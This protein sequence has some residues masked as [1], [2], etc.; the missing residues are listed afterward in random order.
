MDLGL[1]NHVALVAASSRGLGKAVAWGLAKEGTKL[2]ICSRNKEVLEK[3]ADE[4]LLET[5][6]TVFPLAMDLTNHEQIDWLIE[7]TMDLFG[8][9]DILV[10]NAGGPPPGDFNDVLE[11]D[12]KDSFHLNLMSAVRLT[13]AVIP[14][15]QKQK[16][17]RIIY[18]TSVTVKQYMPGMV[19]S[20]VIRPSILALMKNMSQELAKDNILVNSICPGYFITDRVKQLIEEKAKKEKKQASKIREEFITDIP[21]A[22]MGNPEEFANLI[23]FLASEKSSYITGSAISIDGGL[24]RGLL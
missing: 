19:L 21:L 4:I 23:V 18:M 5:G 14:G 2:V 1:K 11:I 7:E 6:V 12:W 15:M 3:T 8:R 17:G 22:R 13:K 20:N 24:V 16:W 9:V 10:T